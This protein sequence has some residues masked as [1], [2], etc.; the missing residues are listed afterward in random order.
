M[1]LLAVL[2]SSSLMVLT[3]GSTPRAWQL[4]PSVVRA[5]LCSIWTTRHR[6]VLEQQSLYSSLTFLLHAIASLA[7]NHCCLES[8]I[9][10]A[11]ACPGSL[12]NATIGVVGS[13]PMTDQLCQLR[14]SQM[15]SCL[16]TSLRSHHS[17]LPYSSTPWTQHAGRA[18]ALSG[19]TMYVFV[20]VQRL[21]SAGL[22]FIRHRLWCSLN[23]RFFSDH[24]P[25]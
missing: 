13:V 18:H 14:R 1:A 23:C 16:P 20:R 4:M 7:E 2:L 25:S 6:A 3:T 17:C 10:A 9:N 21:A 12:I 19:T 5:C 22:G 11:F 8:M 24:T 15:L